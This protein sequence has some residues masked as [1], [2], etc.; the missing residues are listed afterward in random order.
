MT[1]NCAASLLTTAILLRER[2]A[3]PEL[4]ATKTKSRIDLKAC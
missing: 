1:A 4:G 3:I 2:L